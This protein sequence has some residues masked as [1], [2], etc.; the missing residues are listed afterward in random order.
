MKEE[1]YNSYHTQAYRYGKQ[2]NELVALAEIFGFRE[3]ELLQE[4]V[5]VQE[6]LP[7]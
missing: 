1:E 4:T 7:F 5:P 6:I 2:S 3:A